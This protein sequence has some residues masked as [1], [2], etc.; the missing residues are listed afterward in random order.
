MAQCMSATGFSSCAQ[1]STETIST[2]RKWKIALSY[3][4]AWGISNKA[5]KKGEAATCGLHYASGLTHCR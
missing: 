2:L 4:F 5:T 3:S 1:P